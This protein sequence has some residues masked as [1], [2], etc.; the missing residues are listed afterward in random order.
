MASTLG[1][2]QQRRVCWIH[3]REHV[4]E[5]VELHVFLRQVVR[6][7]FNLLE[8]P[9]KTSD[10]GSYKFSIFAWHLAKKIKML[11]KIHKQDQSRLALSGAATVMTS[12][13]H[14]HVS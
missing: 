14:D 13:S 8:V 12:R 10:V 6:H 2:E 5:V 1:T 3:G 9:P 7:L 4:L 11:K